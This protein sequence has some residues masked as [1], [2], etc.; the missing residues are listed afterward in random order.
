M[1]MVV[2]KKGS[3]DWD[4]IWNWLSEHPINEGLE[5]PHVAFN[6]GEVWQYMSSYRNGNTIVS[7]YRHRNHIK[8]NDVYRVS[9]QH[10]LISEDSIEFSKK[11]K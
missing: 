5:E 4:F 8:T 2:F 11:I 9:V 6:N 3:P 1:E 7:E 10:E